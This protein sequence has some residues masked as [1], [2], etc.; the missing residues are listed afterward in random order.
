MHPHTRAEMNIMEIFKNYN[1]I[2]NYYVKIYEIGD[3]FCEHYNEKI[4]ID[5]NGDNI[6]YLES[7]FTLAT[8]L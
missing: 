3:Y 4:Q 7:I 2:K 1:P 6:Y 5:E 8:I